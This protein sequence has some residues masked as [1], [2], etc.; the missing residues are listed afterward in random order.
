MFMDALNR[1]NAFGFL[2]QD[3]SNFARAVDRLLE[4]IQVEWVRD[5]GRV[6]LFSEL[7]Y[8][9]DDQGSDDEGVSTNDWLRAVALRSMSD[10]DKYYEGDVS[11]CED[12][13]EDDGQEQEKDVTEDVEM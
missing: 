7:S 10:D 4:A 5:S 13:D 8:P 6:L 2:L 11:A 3:L 1:T 12:D 9:E